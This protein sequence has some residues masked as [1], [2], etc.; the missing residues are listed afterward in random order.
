MA[1]GTMS[2]IVDIIS[3]H[4]DV[5]AIPTIQ[6][7]SKE[8]FKG[9]PPAWTAVGYPGGYFEGHLHEICARAWLP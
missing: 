1:G 6:D 2:N 5:R 8:F 7:I 9:Q 4:K 3:F